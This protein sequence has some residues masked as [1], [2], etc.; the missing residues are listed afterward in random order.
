MKVKDLEVLVAVGKAIAGIRDRKELLKAIF[1]HIK[2][3][4]SFDLAG[5]FV[6][7]AESDLF[8]ELLEEGTLDDLQDDIA[9]QKLLGPWSFSGNHPN[10]WIYTEQPAL[11]AIDEQAGVFPN[12]QWA[13]MQ[14]ESLTQ[15]IAGGLYVH[16]EKIGLLCFSSKSATRFSATD[17]PLFQAI[18]DQLAVA[19]SNVLAHERLLEEKNFSNT[20]L[21]ITE[22]VASVNDAKQLCKTIFDTIKPVFPFDELGL[23]ALDDTGEMHYE[24]IDESVLHGSKAQKLIEEQLGK[25]TLYSHRGSSVAWLMENG[26]VFLSLKELDKIAPHPQ[27]QYM[28]E[29]GT[30]SIIGG[31]LFYGGKAFG[32][33]CFTSNKEIFYTREDLSLFKSIAE[34]ISIATANILANEKILAEKQFKETLLGISEA[35]AGIKDRKDLFSTI[36]KNIKPV[37][38]FEDLGVFVYDETKQ[39][40][41][42]LAVDEQFGI[43]LDYDVEGWLES[44]P[45]ID[46]FI[47][48]GPL[49]ESLD[50]LMEEYPGHPHYEKLKEE[51][52]EQVLGGPMKQGGEAIGM[53]CFWSDQKGFY[54]EKDFA[55]FRSISEQL[56]IAVSNVMANEAIQQ[57]NLEKSV[58]ISL[59]D[60]LNKETHWESRQKKFAEALERLFPADFIAFYYSKEGMDELSTGFEKIGHDEYRKVSLLDFLKISNLT[61]PI[62]KTVLKEEDPA[63]PFILEIAEYAASGKYLN[64]IRKAS[65][66]KF[67]LKSVLALSMQIK[68][69][70][71]YIYINSKKP[72]AYH[73]EH[74]RTFERIAPSFMQSLEKSLDYSELFSFNKLLKEENF[75]LEKE[76]QLNYNFGEIIGSSEA[77]KKVFEQISQVA[78]TDSNVLITGETGT[79]KEL[80]ARALHNFSGRKGRNFIKLNCATLPLELL[81]SELFGHEKG[82]F[83]GAF[84]RR[85]GKF[86]LADKGTIFL[87]EIGEMPVEIQAKLLRVLQEREFERLGGNQVI[88][89]NVRI[90]TAT[91]RNLKKE[92]SKGSFRSDL[93]YRLN[94]FPIHLPPLRER[95]EDI[96]ELAKHFTNKF[97]KRLGRKIK[98]ISEKALKDLQHYNWPGNIRELEHVIERSMITTKT[99]TLD[100]VLE[101]VPV[102]VPDSGDNETPQPLK[103][104]KQSEIDLIM[105]A[106]KLTNGKISGPGGAAGLLDIKPATLESKMRKF[107]IKRMHVLQKQDPD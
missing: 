98:N 87:D 19:V 76:L 28:I 85:I 61:L 46:K 104:Y 52:L 96:A 9:R 74:I 65:L 37:F 73:I 102:V 21:K 101:K 93:Y 64:P 72:R 71:F 106:L 55:L 80:V 7:D 31:P 63:L 92:V 17:F 27:H 8:Y 57:R 82:A 100:L 3:V 44:N 2:P 11:F 79:G 78:G 34:Q 54:T 4:F 25:H 6:I 107:G 30:K 97:S 99:T 47:E 91:N 26:P 23:F 24:L 29:G 16:G 95:K 22:A 39:Y 36:V 66:E 41:R 94:V 1:D 20:L 69:A 38:P 51:G 35:I 58:Q 48:K 40:Q 45:G 84:Q 15:M 5:L 14:K 42:D 68:D 32:M 75:Y 43:L 103:T 62:F 59:I 86:E 49:I 10:S 105:K 33:L 18:A 50:S 67:K 83:T 53:L 88:K 60:G 81:E 70:T 13:F 56:S 77:I 12:P 89:T 90:I